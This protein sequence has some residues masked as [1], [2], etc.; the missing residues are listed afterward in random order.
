MIYRILRELVTNALKHAQ[1][2]E[3]QAE[4]SQQRGKILLE[5]ADNGKGYE[6]EEYR[7]QDHRGLDSI[8]EQVGMLGGTMQIRSGKGA[9]TRITIAMEM[10]G[11]DSYQSFIGR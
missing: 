10:K 8:L 9:G 6:Q 7:H 1:A 3:I 11:E 2:A 5:V 4:L